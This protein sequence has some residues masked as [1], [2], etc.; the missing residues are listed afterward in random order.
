MKTATN[1]QARNSLCWCG[2]GKKFKKCHLGKKE[3]QIPSTDKEP[4]FSDKLIYIK[5]DEQIEGIR[6]SSQLTKKLLDMVEDR[7]D[8]GVSTNDINQWVHTETLAN[9]AIPAPLN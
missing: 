2:S 7:I 5:T 1:L 6:K 4:I 8:E 9:A 3:V